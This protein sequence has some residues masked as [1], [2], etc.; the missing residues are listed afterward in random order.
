MLRVTFL[1]VVII[2]AATAIPAH[3]ASLWF[4]EGKQLPSDPAASDEFGYTVAID[5]DTIVV[6]SPLDDGGAGANQGSVY[7]YVRSGG[8]WTQQAKIVPADASADARFGWSVDISGDTLVAGAYWDDGPLP[9]QGSAYVYVRSGTTWTLQA[10]LQ[11][12]DAA[13]DDRYGSAVAI[14]NDDVIVGAIQGD[15]AFSSVGAAYVYVR[16]GTSWSEQ[17]KLLASDGQTS[18][19]FGSTLDIDGNYVVVGSPFT[20]GTAG[21]TQGAAY[22]FLRSGTN[23]SEQAKLLAGDPAASDQFARSVSISGDTVAAG[24]PYHD[25]PVSSCGATYIF[26]RSGTSWS[27]QARLVHSDATN[28]DAFG[29]SVSLAGNL[30]VACTPFDTSPAPGTVQGS[31]YAFT[32]SGTNWTQQPKLFA[33]DGANSDEFGVSVVTDGYSAVIGA[34]NDDGSAGANQ[35]SSYVFRMAT[36]VNEICHGD[37][38]GNGTIDGNDMQAFVNAMLAGG[39]CP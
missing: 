10:Q 37:M 7:V 29:L 20:P 5:G 36:P 32:R 38:D 23:W 4:L 33:F 34:R 6:G 2:G 28:S 26:V 31:A 21:L 16:S 18:D 19:Y 12:S 13:A 9:N 1:V 14:K 3:G 39:V 22:V 27:Q 25:V 30:L 17:A 8:L 35:G 11:A 24:C 15:G